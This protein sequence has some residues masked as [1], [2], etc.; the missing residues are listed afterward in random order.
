MCHHAFLRG[1]DTKPMLQCDQLTRSVVTNFRKKK[2]NKSANQSAIKSSE[3]NTDKLSLFQITHVIYIA[4]CVTSALSNMHIDFPLLSD[5]SSQNIKMWTWCG[6]LCSGLNLC[7]EVQCLV[8][9]F[10]Y[11]LIRCIIRRPRFC[12]INL[13][14]C[15]VIEDTG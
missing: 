9:Y 15:S 1:Q 11:F 4:P 8:H 13:N 2:K 6:I 7:F 14:F 3:S 5:K 10:S 12:D